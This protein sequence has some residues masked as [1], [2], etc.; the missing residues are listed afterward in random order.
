[1]ESILYKVGTTVTPGIGENKYSKT[2]C[3]EKSS[4]LFSNSKFRDSD[5]QIK[6]LNS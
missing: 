4:S 3:T 5:Y 1:M 6:G 2:I